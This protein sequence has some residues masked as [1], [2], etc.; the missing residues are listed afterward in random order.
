[1]PPY[2]PKRQKAKSDFRLRRDFGVSSVERSVESSL[3]E[4]R[5][6]YC[7]GT[8]IQDLAGFAKPHTIVYNTCMEY[9]TLRV[10]KETLK[11]LRYIYAATGESMIAIV[12]RLATQEL[13]RIQKEQNAN[14]ESL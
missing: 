8:L 1:M 2:D 14:P 5:Q 10:W 11:K 12:D 3:D 7:A 9:H 6:R 4:C 13:E